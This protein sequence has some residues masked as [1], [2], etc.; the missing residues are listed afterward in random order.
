MFTD[1][2][3]RYKNDWMSRGVGYSIPQGRHTGYYGG[4]RSIITAIYN[5]IAVDVASIDFR[6]VKI[7][8]NGKF[9][10]EIP[11][12]LNECLTT[13]ANIDQ[14][15]R[16]LILDIVMSMFD[17]GYVAVV[18]TYSD[19]D[20][21][22]S[23]SYEI[24][25]MRTA[26]I[27]EWYTKDVKVNL[28]DDNLGYK[29]DL[30]VPK[31]MIAIIENPFY[32][33]MNEPNS[34][35]R[36]LVHK[37]N[38]LDAVDEQAS[39]GKLDLILQLPYVVRG[40]KLEQQAESRRK[41]IEEQLNGSKYGIAFTDGTEKIIQLNRAVENNMMTSVEFLTSMLYSQLG[42]TKAIMEGTASE[43]VMLNYY[44]RTVEPIATAIIEAFRRSF[45]TK[46]AR[47]QGQSI[48]F[49]RDP[50]KLVPA[51]KIADIADRLTRNEILSSNEIRAIVGYKPSSDP[52]ADELRNKNISASN[53]D[54]AIYN[55]E[56]QNV[57][58]ENPYVYDEY[59]EDSPQ[60]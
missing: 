42:M 8:Q 41:K 45:L 43:E 30:I 57:E 11:S 22:E 29:H 7:D 40:E 27:T 26:K 1:H 18:P 4:D 23:G 17:E 44:D 19:N 36:R 34:T 53:A 10:E 56:G 31:T 12:S 13:E 15:G 6:H 14:T 2:D 3:N 5:R 24:Y 54:T 20:M 28:Y 49:F 52:R 47:T 51:A 21:F 55:V 37:L 50:F 35:Y 59:Y 60:E 46:T 16:Q 9:L 58:E 25:A 33:L 38:L 32:T 39:S 48:M